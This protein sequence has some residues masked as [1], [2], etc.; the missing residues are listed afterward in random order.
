MAEAFISLDKAAMLESFSY[1]TLKKRI[2]R[3]HAAYQTRQQPRENGGR[4]LLQISVSSLS[5][6]AQQLYW[7]EQGKKTDEFI[8]DEVTRDKD[9]PW[10]VTVDYFTFIDT[11]NEEFMTA[12]EMLQVYR[13][14]LAMS[15]PERAE[16]V[17]HLAE[18]NGECAKTIYNRYNALLEAQAWAYRKQAE[19][20]EGYDM[21]YMPMALCRKPREKGQHYKLTDIQCAKLKSILFRKGL[22]ENRP[23]IKLMYKIFKQECEYEGLPEAPSYATVKRFIEGLLKDPVT[24][25][26]HYRE[27]EGPRKFEADKVLKCRRNTK[28]LDVLELV[29]GD[30]HTCDVWVQV[31]DKNGN[32]RK[33]RPVL[34]TWLD[35]RTRVPLGYVMCEHANAAVVKQ[36]IL[37]MVY[38]T[39]GGVPKEILI[40]NGK[41]FT[42]KSITGQSRKER[43][44]INDALD[45]QLMGLLKQIGI[46][47]YTR[48]LPYH[49]WSKGQVE[50]SFGTAI[51]GFEKRWP[52]YVGTLTGSRTS[53]K[54]EKDIDR[55]LE[56][57]ELPTLEEYFAAFEHWLQT[58]YLVSP[59]GG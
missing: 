58:E 20:G 24:E 53:A 17:R 43:Q 42:A 45:S 47:K 41:E 56:R 3:N 9:T 23:S 18:E 19:T 57:G 55:M 16:T 54:R 34:V 38:S 59:H 5:P 15:Q 39:P 32:R 44:M 36:S 14:L 26:A 12:L 33:I 30:G 11:H 4:P 1:E 29:Q 21:I 22:V 28:A 48:A 13:P 35:T 27:A 50:R 37:K 31:T 2:Q 51:E 8:A 6:R 52:S 25:Q 46:V 49:G 7:K 40:D 10:Y